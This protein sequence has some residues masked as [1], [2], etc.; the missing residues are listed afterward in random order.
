MGQVKAGE[1]V[2][3]SGAAG[4][5]GSMACILAKDK[6]AKVYATA[7]SDDKCRW[8]EEEVGVAK[9][10]NYKKPT[11][12]EDFIREAGNFD[13]F[14]DNVGG[15]VLDFL[16]T[17]MSLHA[18]VL[19][20]GEWPMNVPI[21]VSRTKHVEQDSLQHTVNLLANASPDFD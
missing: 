18:R 2:V 5:V 9:A 17:R 16:L 8:L 12:K 7:G 21:V 10:F 4:A 14:F 19:T 15:E 3:V 6:G 20:C 13:V 11:F 1:V